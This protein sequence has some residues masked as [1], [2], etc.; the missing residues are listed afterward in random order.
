MLDIHVENHRCR[1]ACSGEA[2]EVFGEV[3]IS[4]KS[5]YKNLNTLEQK[6]AFRLTLLDLCT[7][8]DFWEMPI[9]HQTSIHGPVAKELMRRIFETKEG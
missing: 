9:G 4:L 5:I 8:D 7:D 1:I 2:D 3:A 6:L